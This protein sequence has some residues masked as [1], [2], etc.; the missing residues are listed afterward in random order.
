MLGRLFGNPYLLLLLTMTFWG[1]NAVAGRLAAV[2]MT[3]I[4]LTFL[5]WVGACLICYLVAH[6]RIHRDWRALRAHWFPLLLLGGFGF[7]GFNAV[8]YWA[9]NYTTAINAAIIQAILPVLIIGLNLVLFSMQVRWLQLVGVL[10]SIAGVFFIISRGNWAVL[11]AL[12]FNFGDLLMVVAMLLYGGYAVGL[13]N[14]PPL[15]WVTLMF[16]LSFVALLVAT[17]LFIGELWLGEPKFP[18]TT[19]WLVIAYVSVFPSLLAQLFF[20]R[21]VELIGANRAGAYVNLTPILGSLMAIGFLGEALHWFH[22][23]AITLVFVG[24]AIA[25]KFRAI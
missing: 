20:I 10:V 22:I 17:V 13:R 14:K 16:G 2:E 7:C 23:A 11:M 5:R 9:L 18:G 6:R 8:Y 19:G 12:D 25:E 15:H 1:G 24:I 4:T 3:P 21:S